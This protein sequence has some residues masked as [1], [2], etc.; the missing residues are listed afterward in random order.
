MMK[1]R[2]KEVLIRVADVELDNWDEFCRKK[3]MKRIDLIRNAVRL[4][5][6]NPELVNGGIKTV[7]NDVDIGPVLRGIDELKQKFE[8]IEKKVTSFPTETDFTHSLARKKVVEAI[9][10]TKQKAKGSVTT[11]DRLRDQ[12]KET[13]PSL[14]PFL[15]PVDG[16]ISVLD[17][18]LAE[19]NEKGELSWNFRQIIRFRADQS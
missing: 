5:V 13:E 17:E 7:D 15:F 3:G 19:L 18:V 2:W 16:G 1:T 12:L 11:L 8:M 6:A 4:Y 9:L 10:K 14:I